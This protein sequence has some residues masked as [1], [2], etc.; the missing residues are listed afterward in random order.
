MTSALGPVR[1][2]DFSRVLA[3]PLATMV[4]ADLGA[5]VIKVE[6]PGAGDDT[7]GWKPPVDDRG[8]STYF[9]SVNRNK[10]SIALD[11]RDPADI[12]YARELAAGCD[13]VVENFRPGVMDRLGLGYDDLSPENAGLIYT[14]I[15]GFGDR[16]GAALPGYDLLVQAVGGL[17]SITGEADG[18][19]QKVG[20][21]LVDVIAGL[22]SA[23]GILAAIQ[24]RQ[25]TGTG[26]KVEVN[27]LSSLL[28][29][30]VNQASAFTVGGSI[31]GRMGNA[32]PSI[33]P[34]ELFPCKGGD[35]V[36]AVGTDGQFRALCEILPDGETLAA[37]PR[38][39]T[40]A[41]RV[42]NRDALRAELIERLGER[43]PAA[44]VSELSARGVPAGIVND[45][46]GAF[47]FAESLGLDP[48]V[49]VSDED[50]SP[51][52]LTRNPI[53]LSESPAAYRTAPPRLPE[54]DPDARPAWN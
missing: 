48:V 46:A 12:A 25:T 30:L 22:F 11:L 42:A 29:G 14:S 43:E 38:F 37:E 36:L 54:H 4:L 1:I 20:V 34:Y 39:A 3:G 7:R 26:Q 18:E 24:R 2:L 50:G 6:R 19:P 40:N 15:T 35:L 16:E 52:R 17:M 27:L 13:V 47:G 31:P 44:W 41:D 51:V 33:A 45:V 49:E 21:A 8:R 53:G 9:E 32:H 28:A 23:I 10:R 5:D